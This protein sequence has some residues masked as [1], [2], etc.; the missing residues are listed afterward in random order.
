MMLNKDSDITK[1]SL[2]FPIGSTVAMQC[3]DGRPWM[4]GVSEEANN[5]D[6]DGQSYIV[7]ETKTDRLIMWNTRHN[8]PV[9]TER[10]FQQQIKKQT[11]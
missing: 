8:T 7:R 4:H 11:E 5:S 2:S 10:H 6:C 1:D 9:T 3:K